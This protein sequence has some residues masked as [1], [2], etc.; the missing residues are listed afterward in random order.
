MWDLRR[1]GVEALTLGQYMK[2]TKRHMAVREWVHPERFAAW[3]LK[4]DAMGFLYTASGPL[5]RSSY[6]A[7][8]F[9]LKNILKSRQGQGQQGEDEL[10][11]K[12]PVLSVG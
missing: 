5:V 4:G 10:A 7:G 2:P 3:K 12:N 6:R 8:E 11:V 9:Y 1:A